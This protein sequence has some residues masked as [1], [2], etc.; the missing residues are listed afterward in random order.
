MQNYLHMS[1]L[2]NSYSIYVCLPAGQSSVSCCE[3]SQA[4]DARCDKFSLYTDQWC[5]PHWCMDGS[6]LYQR[7]CLHPRSLLGSFSKHHTLTICTRGA[8]QIKGVNNAENKTGHKYNTL[9]FLLYFVQWVTQAQS[10]SEAWGTHYAGVPVSCIVAQFCTP[11]PTWASGYGTLWSASC[12]L[13]ATAVNPS[14]CTYDLVPTNKYFI[15]TRARKYI[16]R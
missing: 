7:H 9:D 13:C 16:V 6:L 4:G 10:F 12:L 11:L 5:H 15:I 2:Y 1:S 8:L 14:A 3:T